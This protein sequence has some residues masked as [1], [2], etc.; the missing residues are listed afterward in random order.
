MNAGYD[1][2]DYELIESV[3]LASNASSV[4]FNNLNQYATEYRHLQIRAT[5]KGNLGAS[6]DF[7]YLR[8]NGDTANN[9]A[10]HRLEA[11]YQPS[12]IIRSTNAINQQLI[13]F[14]IP[15]ANNSAVF[16]AF[17]I[18]ILDTYSSKNKTARIFSAYEQPG[19]GEIHFMS[20]LWQNT[21]ALTS[22]TIGGFS[23]GQMLAGS[24]FSLYGIR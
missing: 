10:Q 24:R 12:L 2:N 11:T 1:F 16:G 5:A 18:D 21:A 4:N 22:I 7:A 15:G 3:F 23:G 19:G 13:S 14:P 17:I 9:Y 8:L 6:W 20:G